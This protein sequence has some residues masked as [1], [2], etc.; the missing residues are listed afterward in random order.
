MGR[1]CMGIH[2][3]NANLNPNLTQPYDFPVLR[4]QELEPRTFPY[5]NFMYSRNF[6]LEK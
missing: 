1:C 2:Y 4:Y 6:L 3:S 5:Y